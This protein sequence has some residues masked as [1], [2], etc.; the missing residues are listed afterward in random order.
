MGR[1]VPPPRRAHDSTSRAD[2][3]RTVEVASRCRGRRPLHA[4]AARGSRAQPTRP[5][6]PQLARLSAS[7][8]AAGEG[9]L[10]GI[11]RAQR[12]SSRWQGSVPLPR[13][14]RR[15][16]RQSPVSPTPHRQA[17][18]ATNGVTDLTRRTSESATL[19]HICSVQLLSLQARAQLRVEQLVLREGRCRPAIPRQVTQEVARRGFIYVLPQLLAF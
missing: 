8:R 12:R 2:A 7:R 16:R 6:P 10:G 9:R 3:P 11:A 5:G 1:V 15:A 13:P 18:P 17:A 4:R 19:G 14:A